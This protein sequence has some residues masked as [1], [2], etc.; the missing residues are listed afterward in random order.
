MLFVLLSILI[1]VWTLVC[2]VILFMYDWMAWEVLCSHDMIE[3]LKV[4]SFVIKLLS[5]SSSL[6][7]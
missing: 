1:I 6:R 7:I 2:S 3:I 4:V 5:V